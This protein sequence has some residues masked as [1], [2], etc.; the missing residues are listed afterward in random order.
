[1]YVRLDENIDA[2]DAVQLD[3]FVFVLPPIAELHQVRPASIVLFVALGE[4]GI[5]RERIG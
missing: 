3:L 2:T 1:M 5:F 4:N